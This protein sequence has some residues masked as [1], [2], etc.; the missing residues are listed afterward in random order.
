MAPL[1]WLDLEMTGLDEKVDSILEVAV[2]VTDLDLKPIEEYERVVYQPPEVLEKMEAWCKKTHGKSGL[3]AKVN[4]G[5][6]L[7]KVEEEMLAILNRH[8]PGKTEKIVL[9]G[10]S[11]YNDKRF[12]DKYMPEVSKRLHYR[13]IDVSSFKEIFRQKYG[14]KVEKKN[15]HRAVDDIRESIAELRTYLGYVK[16]SSVVFSGAKKFFLF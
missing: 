1:L 2:V 12:I 11:V 4:D 9:C 14:I 8:F 7:A 5:I 6:P 15:A 10:N 13:L 3:T 16:V